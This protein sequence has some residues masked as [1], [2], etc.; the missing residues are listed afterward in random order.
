RQQR[1]SLFVRVPAAHEDDGSSCG[2]NSFISSMLRDWRRYGCEGIK[3]TTRRNWANSRNDGVVRRIRAHEEQA[4]RKAAKTF[5]L[6]EMQSP[7]N[8]H[9]LD[10]GDL[11]RAVHQ[12]HVMGTSSVP[13]LPAFD[14]L[15]LSHYLCSEAIEDRGWYVMHGIYPATVVSLFAP[16]E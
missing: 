2:F 15:D 1:A 3:S 14:G 12:S 13:R 7:V 11:W 8:L 6:L 5:R 10:R 4:I 16:G 9:R